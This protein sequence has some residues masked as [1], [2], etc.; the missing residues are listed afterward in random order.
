MKLAY[1]VILIGCLN[2]VHWRL[3]GSESATDC[4]SA[5]ETFELGVKAHPEGLL[6]LY[7]DALQTNPGCRRAILMSA[8]E[9]S[10]GDAKMIR[11]VI[12]MARQEFPNELTLLAEAAL[13]TAPEYSDIIREAFFVDEA[14][15]VAELEEPLEKSSPKSI[16]V[17]EVV[18]EEVVVAAPDIQ[19]GLVELPEETQKIDEDIR[20]SIARMTAKVEGKAWP[21]QVLSDAELTFKQPDELK[22][23]ASSRY[24]D[25]TS[26]EN[27]LPV[28]TL[29]ERK[30]V[31][32][33]I[34]INDSWQPT[35]EIR[36]DESKFDRTSKSGSRMA[37]AARQ[38]ELS[39]AG[40]I[41]V[42]LGPKLPRSS[43][44]YIPPAGGDFGS[45]IDLDGRRE[46]RP[47][48]VIRSA[49]A[50]PTA[51]R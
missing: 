50:S 30:I 25:E 48:L 35:D 51:L 4:K 22:V 5:T 37:V 44:Y 36:L 40:S 49:P 2:V 18:V 45:T 28:D 13:S 14:T 20:E 32:T 7:L 1:V 9:A 23:S 12:F 10:S 41:G 6:T 15:M 46:E 11:W 29:D 16:P 27:S 34:T 43:V 38:R 19:S 24:A 26:L 8:V 39:P 17:E 47:S 42:P 21:E 33:S 31:P 3:E